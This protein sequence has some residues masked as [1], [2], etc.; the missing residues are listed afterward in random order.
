MGRD[1]LTTRALII[2][3][4]IAFT[5]AL[6]AAIANTWPLASRLGT[7]ARDR[8]DYLYEAWLVDWIGHSV[9][10]PSRLFD[11][12]LFHPAS[13]AATGADPLLGVAVPLAPLRWFG[14][15]P[16]AV[17]NV[18]LL[19]ATAFACAAG[20]AC[21][22]VVTGNRAGGLV[23]GV[24]MGFGPVLTTE[25]GHIQIVACAGLPLAVLGA[26]LVADAA[27]AGRSS[28][29]AVA[30]LSLALAWQLSVSFYVAFYA[31]VA[32]A[33]VFAVE[34]RQLRRGDLVRLSLGGLA[35]AAF[36]APLIVQ[37]QRR[38]EPVPSL[39]VALARVGPLSGDFV[40]THPKLLLWGALSG[41][42]SGWFALTGGAFPG[43]AM[44]AFAAFGAAHAWRSRYDDAT[45]RVA[46]IGVALVATGG[47]LALGAA[48]TGWRRFA[49]WRFV[50]QIVP[51]MRGLRA[52]NRAVLVALVGM[53]LLAALAIAPLARRVRIAPMALGMAL[54]FV[55]ALEGF[56]SWGATPQI[57]VRAV[58]RYLA[59]DPTPGAV[60]YLP[61][62]IGDTPTVFEWSQAEVA[63]RTTAHHRATVNGYGSYVPESY[64]A[65][66]RA[67]APF[68]DDASV[69]ALHELGVR[70]VVVDRAEAKDTP[71]SRL[72][73]PATVVHANP[74][75][76]LVREFDADLLYEI[77]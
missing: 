49:P 72:L 11:P 46:R 68:P 71:W 76:R 75:V 4:T 52:A 7:A 63:F 13:A 12:N 27:R 36:A 44:V 77:R 28:S 29:L 59:S 42:G 48:P 53:G 62:P 43:L 6:A 51:P 37:Y 66:K 64:F 22:R 39:G 56:G 45:R 17:H 65:M 21:G 74:E 14:F 23:L 57:E 73:D 55:I 30:L 47:L 9:T 35:F 67:V 33:V 3:T 19:L 58:D 54:A 5:I 60:L 2:E 25:G 10:A 20:Y 70:F 50:L 15:G 26:W 40:H 24:A 34:L 38:P 16:L 1:A 41:R 31:A 8:V 18:G 32:A 61:L 69:A